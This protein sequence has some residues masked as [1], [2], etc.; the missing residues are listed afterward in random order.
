M[1]NTYLAFSLLILFTAC[2]RDQP[3]E[4]N[5]DE[6]L[7]LALNEASKDG[8]ISHFSL[9]DSD[10]FNQIP[11][12]PNNKITASKV[13]LGKF[14]FHETNLAVNSKFADGQHTFSCASCHHAA[15]GF[16]AGIVQGIGDGGFGFGL[17]GEGRIPNVLY[18]QDSLD[19]QP[20][21]T[22]SAMNGAYQKVTLW[23]G[24]FGATGLNKGTEANWTENT[25]KAENNLGFEG[26]ET[27]AIAGLKVHRMGL[28]DDI[29]EN[30]IYK[31]LF[32]ESFPTIKEKGDIN[33]KAAGLAIAAYERT[34]VSKSGT[35]SKMATRRLYR[36][37]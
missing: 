13:E 25:P 11:Q 31:D 27:Q 19:T 17:A 22:P 3:A 10:N 6:Q 36:N 37:V 20:I 24:Q 4:F 15:A 26:L 32:Q 34:V 7:L 21:R 9:P 14:L 35:I 33:R 28:S 8:Q 29:R 12:D 18:E 5:L 30:E 2:K 1:K 23:N 16:Q